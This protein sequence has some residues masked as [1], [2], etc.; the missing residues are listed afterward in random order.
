MNPDD[1]AP[2][3]DAKQAHVRTMDRCLLGLLLFLIVTQVSRMS[4]AE[5]AQAVIAWLL[6]AVIAWLSY[7][8]G[9]DDAR[10]KP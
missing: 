10:T 3:P 8:R 9:R 6:L 1:L 5:I 2:A 4:D 7:W